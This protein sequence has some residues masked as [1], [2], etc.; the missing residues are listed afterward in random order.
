MS[1]ATSGADLSAC[2]PA[3]RFAH[4]GYGDCPLANHVLVMILILDFQ[5][6][7]IHN[8][9]TSLSLRGVFRRRS[10]DGAGRRSRAWVHM[11]H[12]SGAEAVK[13][14]A[15]CAS[16]AVLECRRRRKLAC[17]DDGAPGGAGPYV[18]GAARPKRLVRVTGLDRGARAG[19]LAKGLP[20]GAQRTH[21][22]GSRKPLAPP[23]APFPSHDE[24][25]K[26]GT[27]A[28]PAPQRIRAA[29]RWLLYFS[30]SR[31][32]GRA[33]RGSRRIR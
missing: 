23:G 11:A 8:A 19:P 33:G 31:L 20:V 10:A 9:P 17:G 2:D 16:L 25:R 29:E 28:Y 22:M 30:L 1:E 13:R 6:D 7:F 21:P 18:I 12:A 24:G 5:K 32:R 4:A 15:V 26:K 14:C 3:C 27:T